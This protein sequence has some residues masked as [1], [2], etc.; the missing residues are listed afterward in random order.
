M[1][2]E[3][4]FSSKQRQ[5]DKVF[6]YKSKGWSYLLMEYLIKKTESNYAVKIAKTLTDKYGIEP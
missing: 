1:L 4:Y 3:K 6:E 2:G 5:V